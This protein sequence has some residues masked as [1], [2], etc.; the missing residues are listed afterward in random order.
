LQLALEHTASAELQGIEQIKRRVEELQSLALNLSLQVTGGESAGPVLDDLERFNA[1][2]ESLTG[3]LKHFGEPAAKESAV[4]RRLTS[5]LDEGR[6][7]IA[8][9][10]T[11][12][13]RTETLFEDAQRFRRHSES[14]IRGI[15]EGAV[16]DL[17]VSYIRGRNQAS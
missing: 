16:A 6:R 1:E 9:A 2:L 4:S 5:S 12:K 3:A 7:M 13:E 14:L 11:L 15:Q 10:E 17:P 8:A